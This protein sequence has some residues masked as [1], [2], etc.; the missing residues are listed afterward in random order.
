MPKATFGQLVRRARL[1]QGLPLRELAR[2][3]GLEPSRLSR[4]EAGER[5]PPSLPVIR[6]LAQA[7]DIPMADLIVATGTPKEVLETL[8]WSERLHFPSEKT[9]APF[10]P[11]LSSRNTFTVEVVEE[12]GALKRVQLGE[13]VLEVISFSNARW[14]TI[15]IPPEAVLL[16]REAPAEKTL[17]TPNR[18]PG[19]VRKARVLGDLLNVVFSCPGFELN[20]LVPLWAREALPV[21]HGAE[22]WALFSVPAVRTNPAKEGDG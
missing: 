8:L 18:I 19:R 1:A 2:R 21:E 16:S 15:T 22:L 17:A 7:L 13:V 12:H 9:F 20:A 6:A 10:H 14:L 5:P 3:V 4:I 11:D